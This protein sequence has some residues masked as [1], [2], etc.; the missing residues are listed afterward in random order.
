Y[1]MLANGGRRVKPTLIDRIQDRWGKTIFKHDD[2][3]CETCADQK[4]AD[5]NEPRLRDNR[6]LVIDP[7]SAYQ[8]TSIMQ[9]VIQRGTAA[10]IKAELGRQYVAGKTGTT[11]DSKDVWF[12]GYSANLA[13]GVYMGYDR[14]RSL[15]DS[16]TAGQYAAP[17]F[18]DFMKAALRGQPDTPFKIPAGMKLI[19]VSAGTGLRA[20]GGDAIM[21]AFKPG[22]APP[23]SYNFGVAGGGGGGGGGG[24]VGTGT[25]GLY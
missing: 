19:R 2:R 7:M 22:T 11:N 4:W 15:G 18:R 13:V 16:A 3:Q 6:E 9:G 12:V 24:S 10:G 8:I 14:P 21:E 25:G 23:D 20:S 17:I 1:S 5:Q